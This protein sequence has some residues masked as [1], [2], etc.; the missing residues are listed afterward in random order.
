VDHRQE[1]SRREGQRL[2]QLLRD[3]REEILVAWEESVRA[4]PKASRLETPVLRDEVPDLILEIA[5]AVEGGNG[6][7]SAGE[8][9]EAHAL[10]R[11][12]IGFD[13]EEVVTEY[14][15]LRGCI[16]QLL[17][18]EGFA[19]DV[20]HI[21]SAEMDNAIVMAATRYH[22]ARERTLKALDRIADAAASTDLDQFLPRLVN[23]LVETTPS[24]DVVAIFLREGDVL[25]LRA[26]VG[27]EAEVAAGLTVAV[28]EGFAGKIAA[29]R[30]ARAVRDAA[31]EPDVR[32]ESLRTRG[33]RALYGVPMIERDELIGVAHMASYTAY[34]FSSD[35]QQ[36]FRA[37]ASRA[38][39]LIAL[40]RVSTELRRTAEERE[41]FL[42][43]LGHDLRNPLAA[44]STTSEQLGRSDA[45]PE[46][47]RKMAQRIL[48]SAAR[49]ERMIGEL[50]DFAR[51]RVGRGMAIEPVATDLE[52]IA[53]PVVEELQA[54]Y[55]DRAIR[56]AVGGSCG[57]M[58]D[59]HKLSRVV[60][61]LVANALQHGAPEQPVTVRLH[62]DG[63]HA[64]LDVHNLGEPIPADLLPRLFDPFVERTRRM[65]EG[66]GLGLY[67]VAQIV[68][69]HDGDVAVES[70]A[71]GGT[72]F[73]VR[74]P[75]AARAKGS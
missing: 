34:Q 5:A 35:D 40:Y 54:T 64:I 66:L 57:G 11:L 59:P 3:R 53:R 8:T 37:M 22:H 20:M 74:L 26:A 29:T 7:R 15:L 62:G 23:V 36:L 55:G 58:W 16:V 17:E 72:T 49:M 10:Q 12:D 41:L 50:L 75:C 18:R 44:I 32:V 6:N 19:V 14:A 43:I 60:S 33:A 56:L 1:H 13:L 47:E 63:E 45:L 30:A 24:V 21:F 27:L 68:M 69:A 73:R 52:A 42:G 9:P 28:G 67:I 25:R 46:K 39:G 38:T 4:L 70:T 61:N 65:K 2:A 71:E 48:R 31:S 51:V